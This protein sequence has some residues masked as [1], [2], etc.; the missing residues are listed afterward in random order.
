[1]KLLHTSDWH[2]GRLLCGHSRQAEFEGFLAWLAGI[3]DSEGVELL[4][5]SGDVFDT[6]TPSNR[7]QELYYD[8]LH[9]IS[10]ASCRHVIVTGGNHDSPSFLDAPKTLLRALN[11]HV[12]GAVTGEPGDEVLVLRDQS[13]SPEAVVCA[14]PY[15]RDRDIRLVEPGESAGDKNRKLIEGVERHYAGV[16]ALADAQRNAISPDIPLIATGHLF[17]AGGAV[18][19]GDGVREIYVGS[20]A[21]VGPSAFPDSIDYLALGHLHIAQQVGGADHLRY[22]GSPIPM[23]FGEAT[24]QK[25]VLL[26]EFEGRKP[27]VT[28]LPVPCFRHLERLAGTLGEL[29]ARILEL[30]AAGST[31]W[32]EVD[33]RGDEPAS[34]VQE[35]LKQAVSGSMLEILRVRS[36]RRP[37]VIL[38]PAGEVEALEELDREAVFCR[39]LEAHGVDAPLRP[40]LLDCYREVLRSMDEDDAH[41]GEG[42]AP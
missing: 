4:V 40:T 37:G 29:S 20:L 38:E 19:D 13:G 18:V 3:V 28:A 5:V 12:L 21:R 10:H 31:A 2:L 39:C 42:G 11:V 8:F 32:L 16:C 24:Q 33:Y 34:A 36:C 14:V 30:R 35:S 1:M 41:A 6:T 26:V 7:V 25:L 9:N 27:T 17:T 23:G 15:L 22:S